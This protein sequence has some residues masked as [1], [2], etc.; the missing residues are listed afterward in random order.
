MSEYL[1][2]KSGEPDPEIE[3]LERL[4]GPLGAKRDARFIFPGRGNWALLAIAASVLVLSVV[5]WFTLSRKQ[6]AWH[7]SALGGTAQVTTLA[8]GESLTTDSTSRAKLELPSVGE[9]EV[10]PN[11]QLAVVALGNSEQRLSLKRGKISATIWAPPG[12]F[13]VNTP[14]AATVDLGCAYTLEV[15]GNGDALARVTAGWVAFERDGHESFIPA[16]AACVTR[17][18]K[19]PGIPYYEDASASLKAAVTRFD[20]SGEMG[21][22]AQ[23]AGEARARDAITLWHLLQ[24]VPTNQRGPVFDRLAELIQL[25]AS[26][27]RQGIVSGNAQMIDALWD[28]LGLG[29]TSWWR[30][31]KT[32][33]R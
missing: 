30:I 18:G 26:V 31:W 2:D 19:G 14:S 29:D 16:T 12:Q 15:N 9:V 7:V 25:P 20:E 8:R 28:S 1:W 32:R 6:V 21:A 24:R 27:N 13:V 22:V 5:G 11:S 23:I 17:P 33:T 4:L 10:E 3:G